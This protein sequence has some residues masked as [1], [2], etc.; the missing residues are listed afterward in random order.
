MTSWH[1][2]RP[3]GWTDFVTE[4]ISQRPWN[5][6]YDDPVQIDL[7]SQNPSVIIPNKMTLLEKQSANSLFKIGGRVKVEVH[8]SDPPIVLHASVRNCDSREIV[9]DAPVVRG[10]RV[11]VL[12]ETQITLTQTSSS[13]LMLVETRVIQVRPKPLP[14]WVL[15]APGFDGIRLI[16]RRREERFEVDLH[17]HWK[18]RDVT[19]WPEDHLLQ[20]VNVNTTGAFI[21]VPAELEVGEEI[22][23]DLTPLIRIGGNPSAT[24][25]IAPRCKLVRRASGPNQCYGVIFENLER[26]EKS[27]LNEGIRRLKGRKV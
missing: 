11:G 18:M 20:L 6:S 12:P 25:R 22:I 2:Q 17:L 15:R 10:K 16:Q 8:I 9:L 21:S 1:F 14:V 7:N 23:I 26:M 19:G 3:T 13:G 27:F 4:V 5:S 24:Q